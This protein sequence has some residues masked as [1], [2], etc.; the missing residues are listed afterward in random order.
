MDDDSSA[1]GF[2]TK[3]RRRLD[4]SGESPLL[5]PIER[6]RY[7]A[8]KADGRAALEKQFRRENKATRRK[9]RG[10]SRRKNA[11]Q[12]AKALKAA[13][14]SATVPPPSCNFCADGGLRGAI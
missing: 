4:F 12:N 1:G 10:K 8:I 6:L 5:A 11:T 2:T 9:E 14:V 7:K 13:A 3:Q